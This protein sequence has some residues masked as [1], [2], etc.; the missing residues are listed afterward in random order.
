[1]AYEERLQKNGFSFARPFLSKIFRKTMNSPLPG[2]RPKPR[3]NW[4]E[5]KCP[6]LF[7]VIGMQTE[8]LS[9]PP[10]KNPLGRRL[11]QTIAL[12]SEFC[13]VME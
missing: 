11:I 5:K 4:R 9:N 3:Y 1:M 12:L 2:G 7:L 13:S 6:R 8:I 10:G